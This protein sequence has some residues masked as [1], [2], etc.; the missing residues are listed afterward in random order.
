MEGKKPPESSPD[1]ELPFTPIKADWR[2]TKPKYLTELRYWWNICMWGGGTGEEEKAERDQTDTGSSYT[3]T[4]G[5]IQ[6]LMC[7]PDI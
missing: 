6:K 3:D 1:L 2:R 5:V 4:G 7:E